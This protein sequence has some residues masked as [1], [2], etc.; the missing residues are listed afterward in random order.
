MN[1]SKL[2]SIILGLGLIVALSPLNALAWQ[3]QSG[4]QQ[5]NWGFGQHQPRG[6]AYGW[7]GQRPPRYQHHRTNFARRHH[8]YQQ[9]YGYGQYSGYQQPWTGQ[10]QNYGA[11]YAPYGQ[12]SAYQQPWVGQYNNYGAA[13]GP[14]GYPR[15]YCG[16]G[17][18]GNF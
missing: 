16:P 17:G 2:I 9:P 13:C 12:Y 10:Y 11:P 14:T 15:S 6:H 8:P 1:R 3:H 18:Y 4:F 7:H 5:H